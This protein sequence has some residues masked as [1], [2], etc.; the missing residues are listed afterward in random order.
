MVFFCIYLYM[1]YLFKI[2]FFCFFLQ[3]KVFSFF[4]LEFIV[5]DRV[6]FVVFDKFLV[7]DV[8][9]CCEENFKVYREYMYINLMYKLYCFIVFYVYYYIYVIFQVLSLDV[10]VL[11][12]LKG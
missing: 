4:K 2:C 6:F 1:K 7:D 8:Q 12:Y 9:I 3:V 10:V 11:M 5:E